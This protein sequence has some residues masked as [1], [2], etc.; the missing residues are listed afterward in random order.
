VTPGVRLLICDDAVA[1]SVL[2]THWMDACVG[3]EVVGVARS[4]SEALDSAARLAPDVILVDHMLRGMTSEELVPSICDRTPG[5]AVVVMSGMPTHVGQSVARLAGAD[6][7]I[8]KAAD[9]TEFCTA[10]R[11]A[12]TGRER[13]YA[14]ASNYRS[15]SPSEKQ[16]P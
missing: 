10:V 16:Q 5:A 8:S 7:F 3:I 9:A 12:A 2:L 15:G 6:A 1:F 4:G 14:R 11:D 13:R